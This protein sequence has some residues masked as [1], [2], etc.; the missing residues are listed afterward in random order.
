MKGFTLLIMILG[1]YCLPVIAQQEGK[2]NVIKG[3]EGAD[4]EILLDDRINRAGDPSKAI[5]S[6]AKGAV[7]RGTDCQVD[8]DNWTDLQIDCYVDGH[9]EAAIAPFSKSVFTVGSGNVKLYARAEFEDGTYMAW[10]PVSKRCEL[11]VFELEIH[12]DYFNWYVE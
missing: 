1:V 3:S 10:G 8:F 2:G 4:P 5:Q 6:E 7:S 11:E 9:L 12:P